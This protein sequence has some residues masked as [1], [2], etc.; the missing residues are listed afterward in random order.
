M[1]APKIYN[2]EYQCKH[3]CSKDCQWFCL[4][5]IDYGQGKPNKETLTTF[6]SS[7][8]ICSSPA[9]VSHHCSLHDSLACTVTVTLRSVLAV[10]DGLVDIMRTAAATSA[11]AARLKSR[12]GKPVYPLHS[13]VYWHWQAACQCICPCCQSMCT[14]VDGVR[15]SCL[16]SSEQYHQADLMAAGLMRPSSLTTS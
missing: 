11:A 6:T 15:T 2:T 16:P 7:H 10:G 5:S 12:A 4:H 9:L 1:E 14:P 8:D 13:F 3:R